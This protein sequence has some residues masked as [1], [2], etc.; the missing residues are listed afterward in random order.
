MSQGDTPQGSRRDVL[1]ALAA[2]SVVGVTGLAGCVGS[3]DEVGNGDD[4]NFDTVQFGVLEP[5]TGAFSDLAK[6]RHQGTELAI[7]QINESDE[8]D[9][10]IEYD[11]YDTQLDPATATQRADQA[12]Q[13][14]GAQFLTG[15]ISSSSALAINDF[16]RENEVVYTPGAAD[17]SITGEECNQYVFRFETSTAQIAEVMAQWTADELGDRIVYHIADYAYGESVLEEVETR[18]ESTSDSYER[19]GV[20]RSD[21]GSNDFEAFISQISNESDEADALVVGM[22]GSDLAIFLSQAR[23]RGLQNEIPIVTT[24]GSFR[25][26]RT[27]AGD[28]AYDIYSG[29]RYVPELETGDNREFVE[30]YESEYDGDVPDNFSRVGYESVRMVANGIREAGSRNPTTVAETLPGMEHETIFGP[31]EF[32]E[33]DQQ[34]SN[35]VWMGECVDPDSGDLATVELLEELPGE[36]A[37]PDCAETGCDL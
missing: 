33:C 7:K 6:E 35:P 27:G 1:R 12:V 14:D 32:R 36:E 26:I 16:A 31:N 37:A 3:P 23:S 11:D 19:V 18:M 21:Q 15:C 24:T 20:T 2:G 29:V 30:A 4:E 9:F 28:G 25:S 8:F 22:T 34:A 10:T 5:F 17:V 13:S